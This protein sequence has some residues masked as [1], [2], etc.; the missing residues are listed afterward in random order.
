MTDD[1]G[2]AANLFALARNGDTAAL[3]AHLDAG[4]PAD[5]A[6]GRGDTLLMLAAYHG[7][8]ATVAELLARGA[9]ADQINEREQTPLA[10]AVFKGHA[11]V[12]RVLLAAGAD[13]DAGSPSARQ[14]AAMF[15]RD[16]LLAGQP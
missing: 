3:A 4:M 2:P 10:G 9:A 14:A 5:L 11:E 16:D 1:P 7:H 13:P 6:N 12:V 8:P 15:G